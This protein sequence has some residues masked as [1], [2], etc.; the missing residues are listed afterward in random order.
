MGLALSLRRLDLIE[1]IFLSSRA[2]QQGTSKQ[3]RPVH[4]EGLLRYVLNEVISGASGSDT[5]TP[6]FRKDVSAPLSPPPTHSYFPACNRLLTFQFFSLLL[7]LFHLNTTPDWQSIATIWVQSGEA[8]KCAEQLIKLLTEDPIEAYQIGFDVVE[9]APQVFV[10]EVRSQLE[11]AGL[12]SEED[13]R[14]FTLQILCAPWWRRGIRSVS[15][16]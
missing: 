2:P 8:E 4:D 6:E 12:G 15:G 14:Y 13:V 7:S 10:F 16:R 5:I 11:K 3:T 1:M 9:M